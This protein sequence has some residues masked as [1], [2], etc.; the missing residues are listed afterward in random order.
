MSGGITGGGR[1][2]SPTGTGVGP[3][4]QASGVGGTPQPPKGAIIDI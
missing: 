2:D 4:G 1:G 3:G